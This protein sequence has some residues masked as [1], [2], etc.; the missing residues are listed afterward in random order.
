MPRSFKLADD[1]WVRRLFFLLAILYVVPFWT[2][3][4]LPTTDGPCHTYNAWILRQ[5]ANVREYPLFNQYYEIDFRPHPNWTDHAVMAL[6]M[7]VVPPLTAEKLLVSGYMLLF[8]AGAWHRP[9]SV[10]PDQP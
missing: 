9:G 1:V 8:L 5:H 7:F 2:T 6:L 10:L 4:Y 3:R